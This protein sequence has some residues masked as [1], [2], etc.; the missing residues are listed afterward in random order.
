MASSSNGQGGADGSQQQGPAMVSADQIDRLVKQRLEQAFNG[1]FGRL[2]STSERAAQAAETQASAHKSD[3]LV[4]GLKIDPFRPSSREE[5][6]KQWKE[7]WFSFMN[8]VSGHDAAYERD[9]S[10]IRLEEEVQL[11]MSSSTTYQ[12]IR[13]WIIQFE[14]LNAPWA[15][16]L[17]GRGQA[18]SKDTGGPTPM[19]VDVVK[20]KK[21]KD[22]KGKGKYGKPEKGKGEKGKNNKDN[23]KGKNAWGKTGKGWGSGHDSSWGG[24]G[25]WTQPWQSSS[26][27]NGGWQ[28][29]WQ[30]NGG[31]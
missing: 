27:H 15:S 7:W 28:S 22:P 2:L 1:V 8:Y 17:S 16:S 30:D 20:G 29:G 6:L 14:N 26:W 19:E 4:K 3:S 21:G 24:R 31:K 10:E 11:R 5:E 18:N 25:S 23:D 13:E 9:I 12:E